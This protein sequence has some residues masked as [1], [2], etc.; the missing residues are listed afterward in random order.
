MK[1]EFLAAPLLVGILFKDQK[2]GA[3]ELAKSL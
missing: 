2:R 1:R 3:A